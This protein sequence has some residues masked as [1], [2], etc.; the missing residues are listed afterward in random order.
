MLWSLIMA[1]SSELDL[2]VYTEPAFESAFRR[3]VA[4]GFAQGAAGYAHDFVL[5]MGR[6]PFDLADIRVPVDLWYGEH[7]RSTVHSPDHGATLARR[8]PTA[9]RH[10][11]AEAGG[12]LLWTHAEEILASLVAAGAR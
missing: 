8:L 5:A 9:R 10:L 2:G 6:W 4:E 3:A 12:S 7:D 1:T 11:L